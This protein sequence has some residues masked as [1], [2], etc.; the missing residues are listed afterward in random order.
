MMINSGD[1]QEVRI[2]NTDTYVVEDASRGM[3]NASQPALSSS[4]TK[5]AYLI[6]RRGSAEIDIY[7]LG[8]TSTTLIPAKE[9]SLLAE[10]MGFEELAICPW[11]SLGWSKA[12]RYLAFFI[13]VDDF[14][15]LAAKDLSQDK[16]ITLD[17]TKANKTY[18]RTFSW[19]SGKQLAVVQPDKSHDT[20]WIVDIESHQR[21]KVFGR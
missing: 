13:C 5:L 10:Q 11:S 12:D 15:L 2:L 9:L 8:G 21:Q 17:F 18:E 7:E 19:I 4:G 3:S 20:V 14:S 1:R 16:T 6:Q